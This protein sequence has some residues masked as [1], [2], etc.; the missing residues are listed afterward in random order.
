MLDD[1][2][3]GQLSAYGGLVDTPNIDR[4]A[5][6]GLRYSNYYTAPICSASRAA[7]LTGRNTHS[8]NMGG[9]ANLAFPAEGYSGR[10]PSSAG[11]VAENLRQGGYVTFQVGKWDHLPGAQATPAGPFTYWPLQQGFDRAYS[12]LAFDAD[13][14][15]PTLT[16]DNTA[17]PTPVADDYFFTT[18]MADEAMAMI[19]SRDGAPVV[20]PF[21]L[22]WATGASHAPHHAPE[23][24]LARYRG[25]FDMGWDEYRR[26]VLA[27]QVALGLV[28]S[29]TKLAPRPE[30]MPAWDRLS[31]D[32]KRLYARQMEA[33]AANLAHA[34]AQFG[35]MLDL[36]ERR[37]EL[38]NTL[39]IVTS[40]N[41]ASAESGIDG[42]MN[43][44][45]VSRTDK[46]DVA[47]NL[48][49]YDR[50]GGPETFP[51]YSYGWTVA[52]NTPFR[53][54]KQT[55]YE[56]GIHVPL[57]VSWPDG[58]GDGDA[59]LRNQFVHVSDIAPTILELAGVEPAQFVNNTQQSA[60]EGISFA[61]SF[62]ET[63]P[64]RG[65]RAQYFELYGNKGLVQ[66]GWAIVTDYRN[67]TW[68]F[69]VS[70]D[71]DQPWELYDIVK[72]PGQTN[73]LADQYPERVAQMAE[74]FR[75]QGERYNVFPQHDMGA[76]LDIVRAI[77]GLIA[78]RGGIW[79][80][81]GVTNMAAAAAPPTQFR[82]YRMTATVELARDGV[83]GPVFANGGSMGGYGLYLDEG[84]PVFVVRG[85]QG[86]LTTVMA[87]IALAAGRHEI[88]LDV[89]GTPA[90][91][92]AA[93]YRVTIA[94]D[95]RELASE[96]VEVVIPLTYNWDSYDI[97]ADRGVPIYPEYPVARPLDGE[98]VEVVFDFNR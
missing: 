52:G 84:R 92:G 72:D 64:R 66:D 82:P 88:V 81:S 71:F 29:G 90:P 3:F 1:V 94:A 35:R 30:G 14:F 39:V 85:L 53:Y 89:D 74:I 11:T 20:R 21:F 80:Y 57:V 59:A 73:N 38:N 87:D 13:H 60:L 55:T 42:L 36:L 5:G 27:R 34:D 48:R 40:D 9:H 15:A 6:A 8:V 46:P 93:P 22:Y 63:G 7:L 61:S 95:G 41:G 16:R 2:G 37:G 97:G 25:R 62:A 75:Q 69:D 18:D 23:E 24:W 77:D 19:N 32:Q 49:F 56:G 67:A 45:Y 12:F 17:I 43:E 31:A 91:A 68:R 44:A 86:E 96:T 70:G 4:V 28:A 50:W 65:G 33:F 26:Q 54:Y 10:V 76:G 98:I 47:D 83:T 58:I 51:G 78:M 79:R